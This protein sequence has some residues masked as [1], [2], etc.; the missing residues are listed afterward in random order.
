MLKMQK[1]SYKEYYFRPKMIIKKIF[2]IKSLKQ[3][4]AY[5][6]AGLAV[7]KFGR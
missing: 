4:I 5:V 2:E 1:Q 3:F 7:F 6:K